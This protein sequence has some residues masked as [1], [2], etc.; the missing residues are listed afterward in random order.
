MRRVSYLGWLG[1]ALLLARVATA[2]TLDRAIIEKTI[3]SHF[4]E[5]SA[6]YQAGL[7]RNAELTGTVTVRLA[8]DKKGEVASVNVQSSTLGDKPVEECIVKAVKTWKFP[9]PKGSGSV[10]ATYPFVLKTK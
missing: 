6:C 10:M 4:E 5:V 3:E 2:A 9:K 1:G 7:D 8:I